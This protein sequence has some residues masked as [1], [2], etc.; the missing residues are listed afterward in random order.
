MQSIHVL[1][2]STVLYMTLYSNSSLIQNF[3]LQVF[4]MEAMMRYLRV[5]NFLWRAKRIEYCLANMWREQTAQHRSLQTITGE[6]LSIDRVVI[7]TI[8]YHRLGYFCH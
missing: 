6:H 8:V 1:R 4:T 3:S 7:S 2:S 5:F